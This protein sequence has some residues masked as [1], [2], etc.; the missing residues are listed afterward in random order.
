MAN[1]EDPVSLSQF[2]REQ[3]QAIQEVAE[4]YENQR[5]VIID[6]F[7]LRNEAKN[8]HSL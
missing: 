1:Q 8:I 6:G 3:L 7:R 4:F 2:I 5:P